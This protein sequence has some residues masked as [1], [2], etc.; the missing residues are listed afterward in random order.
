MYGYIPGK[1]LYRHWRIPASFYS[2][3]ILG[4]AVIGITNSFTSSQF[5]FRTAIAIMA[6]VGFIAGVVW[7]LVEPVR[8][9]QTDVWLV[10]FLGL[11]LL[12][13]AFLFYAIFPI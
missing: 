12:T 13:L 4:I 10:L 9:K 5:Q 3:V 7:Q 6:P 8:R 2:L 11:A 1:D